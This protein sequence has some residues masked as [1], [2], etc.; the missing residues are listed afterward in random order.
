[1]KNKQE[2]IFIVD[3]IGD[4]VYKVATDLGIVI[5]YVYGDAVDIVRN[6]KDKD[7]SVTLK[8]TKYVLFALY[9]PFIESRGMSG[10][11]ADVSI[12][13]MAIATLTNSD[14]EPMTRYQN[15]FKPTLYPIYESFLYHFG[16]DHHISSK[17]PNTI[18]HTKVDIMGNLPVS[19]V[20]DF[21]DCINLDNFQFT[22]N[23]TK[24]C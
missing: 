16:R 17:D 12:R 22:V 6:L 20:N 21:I 1:M 8:N 23:S 15:T 9:M 3:I 2:S 14:D 5:N 19:G 24:Y 7:N 4:V 13:R 18:V 11:Y 10:L